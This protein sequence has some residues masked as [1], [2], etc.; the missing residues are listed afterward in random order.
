[1]PARAA[2][3]SA[4]LCCWMLCLACGREMVGRAAEACA[5]ACERPPLSCDAEK[6]CG[7]T[8][9]GFPADVL[10][11]WC[12]RAIWFFVWVGM[13]ADAASQGVRVATL[14]I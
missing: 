5:A 1:M 12:V 14:A 7:L 13:L 8:L 9:A 4:Q 11:M 2:G 10:A 3:C 6:H